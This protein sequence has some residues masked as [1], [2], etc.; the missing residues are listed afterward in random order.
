MT[1]VTISNTPIDGTEKQRAWAEDIRDRC[2][3]A[4]N[5]WI[6]LWEERLSNPDDRIYRGRWTA[7]RQARKT[8]DKRRMTA[9]FLIY[10]RNQ[11]EASWWIENRVLGDYDVTDEV[12]EVVSRILASRPSIIQM[13]TTGW[14]DEYID[15]ILAMGSEA[16]EVEHDDDDAS[17]EELEEFG[18]DG[19]MV[20]EITDDDDDEP[21]C[22]A[23]FPFPLETFLM[24]D[25]RMERW[26]RVI[27]AYNARDVQALRTRLHAK[28][29]CEA[30]FL[31][32]AVSVEG[33]SPDAIATSIWVRPGHG[34]VTLDEYDEG[35]EMLRST[36]LVS[37]RG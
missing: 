26:E 31:D 17:W 24:R 30:W 9:S 4:L 22:P 10:L 23:N 33:A 27:N 37:T 32:G 36:L 16:E 20:D 8:A 14:T 13:N 2:E 19:D 3:D 29:F 7:E 18:D 35:L 15:D 12:A 34:W 6:E 28:G 25:N 5:R 1:R 11:T 21:T